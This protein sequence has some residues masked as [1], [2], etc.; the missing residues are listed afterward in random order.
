MRDQTRL[1]FFFAVSLLAACSDDDK[2]DTIDDDGGVVT[3]EKDAGTPGADS[4]IDGGPAVDIDATLTLPDGQVVVPDGSSPDDGARPDGALPD[5][6]VTPVGDSS[7]DAAVDAAGPCQ[8]NDPTYGCGTLSGTTWISFPDFEVDLTNKVAW[9]K[10]ATVLDDDELAGICPGLTNGG[11]SW[12]LPQMEDVRKLAAGCAKTVPGGSCQV[13]LDQ[14]QPE[15]AGDCDC[16]AGVS[17]PNSGKFCRPEVP[18]CDVLW[19]WTHVNNTDPYEHWFY[20][21][22]T[23]D[24]VHDYVGVGIATRAKGRCMHDLTDSELPQL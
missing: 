17:G 6:A 13:Y 5:G 2:H 23:G 24:I 11:L 10:P 3:G 18:D 15:A 22:D 9:T 12:E 19:V 1:S 21:P 7:V 20:D 14:V 16:P 4:A 8:V